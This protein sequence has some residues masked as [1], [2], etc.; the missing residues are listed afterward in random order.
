VAIEPR[1][2]R[3]HCCADQCQAD[4]RYDAGEQRRSHEDESML[5]RRLHRW[6]A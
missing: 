4:D 2:I 5:D 6:L 3:R 1:L